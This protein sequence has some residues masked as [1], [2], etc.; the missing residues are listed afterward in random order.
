MPIRNTVRYHT[1]PIFSYLEQLN[2]KKEYKAMTDVD[3]AM[4]QLE[5]LYIY[6]RNVCRSVL[7]I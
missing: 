6:V 5:F 1:Y 2:K 4:E 7:D 3:E